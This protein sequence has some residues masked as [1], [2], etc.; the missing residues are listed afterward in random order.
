MMRYVNIIIIILYPQFCSSFTFYKTTFSRS[1][2]FFSST[3]REEESQQRNLDYVLDVARNASLAA[4]E[5]MLESLQSIE[6]L[7]VK[8]KANSQDIVTES[9]VRCQEIIRDSILSHF[10]Q[11][12]FLGEEDVDCGTAASIKALSDVIL[13]EQSND[14]MLWIVDPIDGTTNFQAG[15]PLFCVSIGV[16]SFATKE[17]EVGLIYNPV[18]NECTTAI[19]GQGAYLNSKPLKR[20]PLEPTNQQDEKQLRESIINIGFPVVEEQTLLLS[21]RAITTLCTKVRGIRMIACAAQV[22]SWVAQSKLQ[23]YISWNLNSWDICAGYLIVR[24]SGGCILDMEKIASKEESEGTDCGNFE[25]TEATLESR[26]LIVTA[27]NSL[28]VRNSLARILKDNN[29]LVY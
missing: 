2:R 20:K 6:S 16:Y 14:A 18:L 19:R 3:Q 7:N 13:D 28:I 11:D 4:G 15:L 27:P 23:S 25:G 8:T 17:V 1:L 22:M 5:V 21:S 26:D 12:Q 10:P 24:E 9:D 29:C